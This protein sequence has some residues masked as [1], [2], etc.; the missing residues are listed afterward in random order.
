MSAALT[1]L[2]L[3]TLSRLWRLEQAHKIISYG[4]NPG[5]FGGERHSAAA[6]GLAKRG[7]VELERI[8]ERHVRYRI[9]HAGIA[10]LQTASPPPTAHGPPNGPTWPGRPS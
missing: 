3:I 10:A 7:L 2:Q 4:F 9:S 5:A 1:P 8:S 6:R